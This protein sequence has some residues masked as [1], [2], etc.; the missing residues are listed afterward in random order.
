VI[1]VRRDRPIPSCSHALRSGPPDISPAAGGWA[2]LMLE[3]AALGASGR[4]QGQG[5]WRPI[6]GS[7]VLRAN[8]Q[9]LPHPEVFY[10]GGTLCGYGTVFCNGR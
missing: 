7:A 4:C 3:D 8:P 5:V 1:Q 6:T 10:S 9:L 2:A